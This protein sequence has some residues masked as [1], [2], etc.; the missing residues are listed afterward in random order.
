MNAAIV[1]SKRCT[2]D[3]VRDKVSVA[4]NLFFPLAILLLLTLI[5]SGI[6]QPV[7]ELPSLAPGMAVFG[8]S[9]ICLFSATLIS[10]DRSTSFMSRLMSSPLKADDII[11][12]YTIPQILVALCQTAICYVAA[13]V[14]G[15]KPSVHIIVA[16][17]VNLPMA[18]FFIG[19][20]LLCGTLFNDRQVGGICGALLTNLTAWLSGAWFDPGLVGGAFA[21]LANALPFVHAVKA[22]R[23]ALAGNYGA[24]LPDLYWVIGWAAFICVA[25]VLVFKGKMRQ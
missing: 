17:L 2:K 25:A 7:F 24:I 14:L 6:P 21:A 4:M 8:L 5:Q 16:I 22:G 3:I 13:I 15:L 20:G 9:F 12:G 11:I 23:A 19:A 10:R 1:F 18:I